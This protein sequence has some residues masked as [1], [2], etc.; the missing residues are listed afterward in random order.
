MGSLLTYGNGLEVEMKFVPMSHAT[1]NVYVDD[2]LPP[3]TQELKGIISKYSDG[4]Y[5]FQATND[6]VLTCKDCRILA[7]KLSELNS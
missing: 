7:E 1:Q 4:F 2:E 5:R 6:S 3:Y